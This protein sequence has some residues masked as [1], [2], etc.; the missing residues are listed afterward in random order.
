MRLIFR[1]YWP[2]LSFVFIL[3][4]CGET[5]RPIAT[6][7]SSGGGDPQAQKLAIVVS[8]NGPS[9]DGANTHINVSGDTNVGQVNLGQ[10]PVHAALV[11]NNSL[12]YVANR[13]SGSGKPSITAYT[14]T[15][16]TTQSGPPATITLPDNSSPRWLTGGL[17]NVYV[18]LA[19]NNSIG[20]LTPGQNTLN[21]EIPVGTTPVMIVSLNN[22]SKL[23]AAN[24]GAG[25][26]S[27]IKQ[28][29][30]TVIATVG[31]GAQPTH[32]AASADSGYVYVVN[33]GSNTVSVIDTATD[34]V[35]GT[36]P[37][38]AAPNYAVFESKQLRVYVTNSGGNSISAIN[39]DK[40]SPNF[41]AVTNIPVGTAPVSLAALADGSR[42][43]VA[44]SGSNSISVVSALSSSQQSVISTGTTMPVSINAAPDS[45]KVI[46]GVVDTIPLSATH[47]DA[48]AILSIRTSDNTIAATNPAPFASPTCVNP[49]P[50]SLCARMKP[51]Y[52]AMFF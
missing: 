41:M 31:V 1:A 33:R 8:T 42:V 25:T 7:V 18:A 52:V 51:L 29:D 37:V 22:G 28:L 38:G 46:V 13:A 35:I 24:Q 44:N 39:A 27:V 47:S 19:G 17:A 2:V 48:S 3:T 16:Q 11:G 12:T 9:G 45:S 36:L 50:A 15:I 32:I 23:Y 49:A 4:S 43:Y 21:G 6:P 20:F 14:T 26:V 30:N 40:N 5:F 34:A 10:D